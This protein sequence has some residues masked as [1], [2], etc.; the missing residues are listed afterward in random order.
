MVERKAAKGGEP[1]K[2]RRYTVTAANAALYAERWKKEHP[3]A[4]WLMADTA[5]KMA[6]RGQRLSIK[7]AAEV[8][9]ATYIS[10]EANSK[11]FKVNNTMLPAVARMLEA[12]YPEEL[13]GRFEKRKSLSDGMFGGDGDAR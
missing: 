10:H 1:K 2:K 12:D 8:V 3:R 7:A 6:H 11:P 4:Y 9:R 13:G 5:L